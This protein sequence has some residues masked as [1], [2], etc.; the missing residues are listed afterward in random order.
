MMLL[1]LH[2]SHFDQYGVSF[3]AFKTT[4]LTKC[5]LWVQ[6]HKSPHHILRPLLFNLIYYIIFLIN[7]YSINHYNIISLSSPRA[8]Q[9]IQ[10]HHDI[11]VSF[12]NYQHYNS[13]WLQPYSIQTINNQLVYP[14]IKYHSLHYQTVWSIL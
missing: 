3:S 5:I 14:L 7:I 8:N 11:L 12:P 10:P 13:I 4:A 6:S 1:L 9:S 2:R